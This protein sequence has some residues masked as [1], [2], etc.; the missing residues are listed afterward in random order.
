MEKWEIEKGFELLAGGYCA[1]GINFRITKSGFL[2]ADN[3]KIPIMN[4]YG[5]SKRLWFRYEF[6]EI[7]I[8]IDIESPAKN[9]YTLFL[10]DNEKLLMYIEKC[11]D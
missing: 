1:G 11:F 8:K 5:F 6:E 3:T 10:R 9:I 2:M 7:E 4:N